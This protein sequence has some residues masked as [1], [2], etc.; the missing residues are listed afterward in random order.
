MHCNCERKV[1]SLTGIAHDLKAQS[2]QRKTVHTVGTDTVHT[3]GTDTVHTVGT[4]TVHTV[5]RGL[6]TVTVLMLS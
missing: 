4:D 1:V 3:V 6:C 2:Q 5:G